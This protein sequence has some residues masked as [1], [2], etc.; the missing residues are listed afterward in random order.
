MFLRN[1][2][3]LFISTVDSFAT[4]CTQTNLA[5]TLI[6][7]SSYGQPLFLDKQ[8]FVKPS[9][10][11][12]LVFPW[13]AFKP[14]RFYHCC[15]GLYGL[16]TATGLYGMVRGKQEHSAYEISCSKNPHGG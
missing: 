9:L 6:S 13:L 10:K 12:N 16:R 4:L 1:E 7:L 15:R 3:S 14:L 8:S 5:F 11:I 2:V